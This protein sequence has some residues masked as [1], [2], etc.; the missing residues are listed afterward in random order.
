M[1]RGPPAGHDLHDVEIGERDDQ[2]EQHR[3]G[4]DV[5]HHRQRDVAEVLPGVGAVDGGGFIEL[6][7]HRFQRRQIH[8]QEERRAVPDIDQDDRKARPVRIAQ[9]RNSPES[10]PLRIQ[11]KAE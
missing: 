9:P 11:L 1:L 4:D 8:D 10:E 6:L 5:A 3:D 2:R 7:R